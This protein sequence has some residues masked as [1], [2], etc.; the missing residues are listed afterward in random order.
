MLDDECSV[1][2]AKEDRAKIDVLSIMRD[3]EK[4]KTYG[5]FE[6]KYEAGKVT[7]VKD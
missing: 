3:F 6:V 7:F 5:G 1:G 2:Y 4:D